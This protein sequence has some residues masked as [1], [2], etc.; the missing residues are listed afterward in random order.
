[1]PNGKIIKLQELLAVARGDSPADL[2]I[3]NAR[4]INVFNGQIEDGSIA[5][6]RNQIVG[7][8][9]YRGVTEID[10]EGCYLAPGLIE[11]HIHIESSKMTPSRFAEVVSPRGTTTVV[12][13]PHEI[14]NVSGIEGIR[15]MIKESRYLPVDIFFML[16][17]CVPATSMETAGAALSAV[18]LKEL[19][20]EE[21]VI[22]IAELMNFPGALFGD[23]DVLSKALLATGSIPIDGHAPNLS[24]KHLTAYVAVGPATD[25]EC[26][27]LEEAKEKL[28]LG[29]RI[30][31]RE[32][33]TA[34]N[35]DALVGLIDAATERRCLFVSDDRR[36]GDLLH[37]GHID[38]ILRLAVSKGVDPVIAIRMVTLNTAE[39]FGLQDR[40]AIRPGWKA[41]LVAFEDLKEFHIRSVWKDGILVAD[42]GKPVTRKSAPIQTEINRLRVPPLPDDSFSVRDTGE[43]IRVI[44][45]IPDKILTDHR[46]LTLQSE[47]GYLQP[48]IARDIAKL[49]IVERHT[50]SGRTSVGFVQGVGI[51][52]G[53]IGS[54]VAHDSHNIIICGM[55]DKSIRTALHWLVNTGGGQVAVSGERVL[56]E[57][58]LPI[59]GLMS[60]QP[61]EVI[62]EKE[63]RLIEAARILGSNLGDPFMALSFLAL[64]VIPK[65][66]LTDY[67]LVD[68]DLFKHVSLH[69]KAS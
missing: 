35:M 54:T 66:K 18:D 21:R 61:A 34:R 4:I 51:T 57:L 38:Q 25:H 62:A 7:A 14:A 67:G 64:P 52:H 15:F 1:M 59:A 16:P 27:T 47:G 50:G 69:V 29:M 19:L 56:A 32:G 26:N 49:V 42:R 53:A 5:I 23:P 3:K 68:V 12:A 2:V 10:L 55:D 11:G 33:S 22:G 24:G 8:G 41:D 13:D 28:R 20:A 60:D 30:M 43:P 39:T 46:I 63:D 48:D 37:D 65:L 40:G 6:H 36:P 58:S 45:V 31:I 9:E 44:G 17:S